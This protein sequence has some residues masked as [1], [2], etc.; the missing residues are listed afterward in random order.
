LP[1]RCVRRQDCGCES[2]KRGQ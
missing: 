1:Y 2:K